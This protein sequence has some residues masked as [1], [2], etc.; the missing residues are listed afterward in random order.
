MREVDTLQWLKRLIQAI[1][2]AI[3]IIQMFYAFQKFM[4]APTMVTQ[5]IKSFDNLEN[6]IL[7]TVCKNHQFNFS[8]VFEELGYQNPREFF[9]GNNSWNESQ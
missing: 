3:F 9:V 7:I 4:S 8:K 6:E 1:A 2:C 5:D